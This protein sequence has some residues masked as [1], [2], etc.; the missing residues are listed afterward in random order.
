MQVSLLKFDFHSSHMFLHFS[1]CHWVWVCFMAKCI[2]TILNPSFNDEG[3]ARKLEKPGPRG[4]LSSGR[5]SPHHD[6]SLGF[7]VVSKHL[8]HFWQANRWNQL[9]PSGTAPTQPTVRI[10]HTAVWSDVADGMYV[11]SSSDG[12]GLSVNGLTGGGRRHSAPRLR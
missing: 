10:G 7:L 9:S 8:S 11:S 2:S 1:G 5:M 3:K 6:S 12:R 4:Q